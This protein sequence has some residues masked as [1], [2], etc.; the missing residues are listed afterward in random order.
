M[1]VG[2]HDTALRRILDYEHREIVGG[3]ENPVGPRE[4][5]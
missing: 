1:G 5:R 3:L 2:D 4:R